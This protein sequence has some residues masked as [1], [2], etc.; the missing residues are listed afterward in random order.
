MDGQGSPTRPRRAPR[1]LVV[2]NLYPTTA[3]PAFGTFVGA[4]VNAMRRAGATVSVAAITDPSLHRNVTRKYLR[5]ALSAG[6]TA[7][8]ARL[9]RRPYDVVEAFEGV[10][11]PELALAAEVQDVGRFLGRELAV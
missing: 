7:L 4:R 1:I 6:W 8:S 5:V 3:H 9:R 10:E 11:V 2:T